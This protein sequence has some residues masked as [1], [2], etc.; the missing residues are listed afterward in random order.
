MRDKTKNVLNLFTSFFRIG[1][2]TFGG[3]YAMI[4][5]IQSEAVETKKWV[6]QEEVLD[7]VAIAES[8]P[9]PLAINSATFI[10]YRVAGVMGSAAATI[11]VVLPSFIIICI[12]SLFYQA[13]M[14]NQIVAWAFMGIRA[15]VVTLILN[16][17]IKLGKSCPKSVFSLIVFLAA[18]VLSTFLHADSHLVLLGSAVL[19]IIYYA[20]LGVEKGGAKQ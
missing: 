11:G 3:G 9:G 15:G 6:T 7:I 18:F 1:L 19:G 13:F 12:L 10:G 4:P 17:V 8:T 2:F 14:S 5:L 16:A 20:V